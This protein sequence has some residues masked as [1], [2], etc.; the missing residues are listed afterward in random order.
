M[1][2]RYTDVHK[3]LMWGIVRYC[4]GNVGQESDWSVRGPLFH[5]T[6]L[7]LGPLGDQSDHSI[8]YN[9]MVM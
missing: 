2:L 1:L 5:F 8:C 3:V 6:W 9:Y 4:K 7:G